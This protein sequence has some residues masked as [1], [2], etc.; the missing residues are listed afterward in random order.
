MAREGTLFFTDSVR[1]AGYSLSN[2]FAEHMEFSL[3]K[4][5]KTA[6]EYDFYQALS[7][8]VK[9]RLIRKWLRTQHHYVEQ[10]SKQVYYLSLE[11]LM[12]RLLG[13]TLINM[14][15][16]DQCREILLKDGIN[17]EEIMELEYD[18]ALGNGGLGRLAACYLDSMATIGIPAC[19]YGI[20]YEYGIFRQELRNGYQ[21]EQ[22]DNWLSFGNPWETLRR[23]ITYRVHFH[24]RLE[25][26]GGPAG[27]ATRWVETEDVLAVAY[28][29]PVPGYRTETVNNLR[30]WQAK[31][32]ND[33]SFSEFDRGNYLA[34]VEDKNRSENISKVLY[35]NDSSAQGKILRLKQEYFFVS[36]SLQDIISNYLLKKDSFDDFP[37]KIFIQLND[38]HPV[39]AIPELMRLL[40]DE[41]GLDWDRAWSISRRCFGYT[42][43]TVVPEALEEWP[44]EVLESLVPRH[45][46]IIYEINSRFSGFGTPKSSGE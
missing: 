46:Q 11:F 30:L 20:R 9:D 19:G 24:G 41:H 29:V 16:Y 39:I 23:D 28:D 21:V 37:E 35:P 43:H 33:F 26:Q 18:M 7:L 22:P 17:L 38:T 27:L 1:R 32:T 15:F 2:Q 6:T 36:A 45:L 12:G 14:E 42:N 44:V 8:A 25:P 40:I 13:N 5:R 10:D 34:A 3:V 31:S 4:T